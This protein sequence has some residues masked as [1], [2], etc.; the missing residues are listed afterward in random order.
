[1]EQGS[2]LLGAVVGGTVIDV[3]STVG[4]VRGVSVGSGVGDAVSVGGGGVSVGM[5]ACVCATAVKAAAT[6]VLC[7]SSTVI[8]GGAG[9]APQAAKTMPVNRVRKRMVIFFIIVFVNSWDNNHL[10]QQFYR[11]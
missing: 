2:T 8:E 4:L 9:V 3:T 7:T 1:M 11:F 10:L 5:D 6:A